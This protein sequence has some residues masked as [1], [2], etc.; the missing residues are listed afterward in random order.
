MTGGAGFIGSNLVG[1]LIEMGETVRVVDNLS[2]GNMEN[3][4]QFIDKIEFIQADLRRMEVC[5]KAVEQVDYVLHQAALPSVPRSIAD[6]IESNVH[7]VDVTLNL[8]VASRDV[9]IKKFVFAGS[10]SVY[11]DSLRLPKEENM[12]ANPKSPY[13]VSKYTGELYCKVFNTVFG[14]PTV[15]LRY[16]NIFGPH[17]NPLS[18]YAAVIPKFVNALLEGKSPTIY[19]D[20]EQSRDFTYVKNAVKANIL[21]CERGM[22]QGEVL[23][24]ACG[25]RTTLNDLLKMLKELVGTDIKAVYT[26][27]RKGDVKH[28]L[29]SVERARESIGYSPDY[30]VYS[31]LVETIDWYKS[32]L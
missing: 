9:C 16:F 7:N 26:E 10:S 2:T 28:S 12:S 14:L 11:G 1:E 19:G 24:I 8:L 15:T 23:N 27:E 21:A 5:V 22:G 18:Q 17:Q 29:A 32:R 13:A 4:E 3:I 30:D 31:G 25:I 6:P 20:G